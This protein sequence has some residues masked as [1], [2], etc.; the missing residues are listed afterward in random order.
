MAYVLLSR[1]RPER[2][3]PASP[4]SSVVASAV[5]DVAPFATSLVP[6]SLAIGTSAA[7]NGL[8]LAEASFGAVVVVAGTA[9]LAAIELLGNDAGAAVVVT[10]VMLINARFTIYGAGL[11]QWFSEVPLRQ[12]LL[13]AFPLVDQSFLCCE[14]RFATMT[15]LAERRRYYLTVTAMLLFAFFAS[16]L[17]GYLAG[18]TVPGWLGLHL[19]APLA[20][21]GMLTKAVK[22]TQQGACAL[23][24]GITML[25]SVGLPS[26]LG[27]PVA[28]FVGLWTG[29]RYRAGRS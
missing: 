10:T 29:G 13:L 7:V 8:T 21:A 24:A 4:T 3:G 16:Q 27:L 17:V 11:G 26:G 22:T 18:P 20:F 5:R 12:R 1:S 6:F 14:A 25:A 23:A 15:G 19:A 2:S 28:I 9:Q